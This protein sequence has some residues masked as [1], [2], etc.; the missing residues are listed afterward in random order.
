MTLD[1]IGHADKLGNILEFVGGSNYSIRSDHLHVQTCLDY[2]QY[3]KVPSSFEEFHKDHQFGKWDE[4][5]EVI[6]VKIRL[7][8]LVPNE[9]QRFLIGIYFHEYA[10]TC[11]C[12]CGLTPGFW[13]G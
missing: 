5:C 8:Q 9:F 13:C 2:I 6:L 12:Q 10:P 4:V 3:Y 7:L 11:C 1:A